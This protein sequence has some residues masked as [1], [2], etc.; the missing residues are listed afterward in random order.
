MQFN[1]LVVSGSRITSIALSTLQSLCPIVAAQS[2]AATETIVLSPSAHLSNC[3]VQLSCQF[4][5]QLS[6]YVA[7]TEQPPT[8]VLQLFGV[9]H[10]FGASTG[11]NFTVFL[12]INVRCSVCDAN[13]R[14][15]DA[16]TTRCWRRS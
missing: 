12:P 15:W 2:S 1:S 14:V 3:A 9:K 5:L 11:T 7:T 16:V 10:P 13:L 4:F 8:S 6:A